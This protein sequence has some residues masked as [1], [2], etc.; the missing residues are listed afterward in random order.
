M[1]KSAALG[2]H[3][4][5]IGAFQNPEYLKGLVLSLDSDKS[6][7]Y[8]HVNK[9][10]EA[11]FLEF[12][13]WC[14]QRDNVHF[15]CSI[16][17]NW[18][19]HTMIQSQVF[20]LKEAMKNEE[21]EI[22]HFISGQDILVRPLGE[23]FEYCQNNQGN[24]IEYR[25]FPANCG[26][27]WSRYDYY[28]ALEFINYRSGVMAK[29]IVRGLVLLQRLLHI[30]RKRPDFSTP[31]SGSCWWSIRRDA[32]KVIN[33]YFA[34]KSNWDRIKYT[35]APDEFFTHSILFNSPLR[36]TMTGHNLTYLEWTGGNG[37]KILTEIDYE[38]IKA[39]G[40]FF[41]RKV[42]PGMSDKL[43]EMIYKDIRQ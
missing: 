2:K 15:Y 12:R 24:F 42:I 40:L 22:F 8:I 11:E 5:L 26:V 43:I 30:K 36:D 14:R 33:D 9:R 29:I 3:A 16:K 35:C 39:S 28:W 18:G 31:M 7:I 10:N 21:N 13:E 32:A 1:E 38:K 19:G 4:F 27:D 25:S 34:N 41:A 23:L 20:L 17:I 6:N 37:P